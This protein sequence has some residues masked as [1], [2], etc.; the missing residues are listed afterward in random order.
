MYSDGSGVNI[1]LVYSEGADLNH[2][3]VI[4][5]RFTVLLYVLLVD[6]LYISNW[7]LAVGEPV[8]AV[9]GLDL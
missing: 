5:Y 6:I 3:T 7:A 4:L 8:A 1:I 9:V 2:H